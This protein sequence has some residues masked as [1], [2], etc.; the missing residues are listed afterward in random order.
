MR[1]RQVTPAIEE[2]RV[3]PNV[4]TIACA[5]RVAA[6][7]ARERH[8][9]LMLPL[10]I[11]RHHCGPDVADQ[12]DDRTKPETAGKPGPGEGDGWDRMRTADARHVL[13]AVRPSRVADEGIGLPAAGAARRRHPVLPGKRATQHEL[14][15]VRTRIL[16]GDQEGVDAAVVIE[17]EIAE[18]SPH[19]ADH[20]LQPLP[21]SRTQRERQPRIPQV[22][23]PLDVR[24]WD[25]V[26]RSD[27]A[28]RYEPD[29][30]EVTEN[31]NPI[32]DQI[33]R[34]EQIAD[35]QQ[36]HELGQ[37][38]RAP[39]EKACNQDTQL[40]HDGALWHGYDFVPDNGRIPHPDR[41]VARVPDSRQ[42]GG[43]SAVTRSGRSV[44]WSGPLVMRAPHNT[45][46]PTDA[47]M[48]SQKVTGA[49]PRPILPARPMAM[50]PVCRAPAIARMTSAIT[51]LA[52]KVATTRY[53]TR[54]LSADAP[55]GAARLGRPSASVDQIDAI[56]HDPCTFD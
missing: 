34:K 22:E 17:G 25:E 50:T 33:E 1:G 37:E 14:E 12:H 3:P 42:G 8:L 19:D 41:M 36:Q 23:I 28:G 40:G 15:P 27:E 35:P 56:R 38:A 54:L 6:H 9:V 26:T 11:M 44:Q 46:T 29:L 51:P 39:I 21:K 16:A 2:V 30:V 24:P 4:R 52:S 18:I 55:L 13:K 45:T 31:R 48:I 5:R 32:R 47:T 10:A 49:D 43:R 20:E 53:K 7:I